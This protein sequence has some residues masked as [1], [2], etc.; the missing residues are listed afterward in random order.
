MAYQS[1]QVIIQEIMDVYQI[2]EAKALDVME[3]IS[4][5]THGICTVIATNSMEYTVEQ[6]L[7]MVRR[8]LEQ[9]VV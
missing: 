7:R 8:T 4:L 9:L 6:V 5:F 3:R 1:N 2:P